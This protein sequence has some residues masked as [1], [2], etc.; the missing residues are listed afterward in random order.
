MQRAA[1]TSTNLRIDQAILG[2]SNK[3]KA[4]YLEK[5]CKFGWVEF[6]DTDGVTLF[7]SLS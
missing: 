5:V 7:L 6:T 4:F 2:T 3:D 1:S